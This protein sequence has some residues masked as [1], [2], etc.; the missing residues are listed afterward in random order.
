[1]NKESFPKYLA[2]QLKHETRGK[3]MQTHPVGI[4]A[5]V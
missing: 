2:P 3:A 1:M 4:R 5:P